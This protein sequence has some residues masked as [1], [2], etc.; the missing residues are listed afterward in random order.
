MNDTHFDVIVLGVDPGGY[1]AAERPRHTGKKVA[2]TEE[3]YLGGIC[4]SVGRIPTEALPNGAKNYLY[5]KE[6]SRFGVDA[7]SVAVNWT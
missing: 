7:Q 3:Q 5:A 1:L 4:L 6:T 2:F